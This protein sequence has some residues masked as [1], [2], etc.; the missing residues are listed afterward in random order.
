MSDPGAGHDATGG[1]SGA[2]GAGDT[3]ADD[4]TGDGDARPVDRHDGR[5]GADADGRP[6]L[7]G[8]GAAV[9]AFAA[10]A[11]YVVAANNAVGTVSVFGLARLPG[12]SAAMALYGA[13]LS[14]FLVGVL[15]GLVT[16]ASRYDDGAV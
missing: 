7:A 8:A 1:G 12:T 13:V 6:Y 16:I 2:P 10:A 11:G 3:P 14:L 4:G 15:F 9:T 5:V